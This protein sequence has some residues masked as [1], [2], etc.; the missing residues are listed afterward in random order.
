MTTNEMIKVLESGTIATLNATDKAQVMA[1][2]FGEKFM[3]SNNKGEKV[4]YKAKK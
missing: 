1:F 2:A 4:K 3:K